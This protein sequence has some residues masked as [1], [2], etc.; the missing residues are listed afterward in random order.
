MRNE[1]ILLFLLLGHINNQMKEESEQSSTA[2]KKL[3]LNTKLLN[4]RIRPINANK[5][6]AS[7]IN[8]VACC[9]S[10]SLGTGR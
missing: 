4:I 6:L 9:Q 7:T 3:L 1:C 8:P 2:D 10:L 5:M